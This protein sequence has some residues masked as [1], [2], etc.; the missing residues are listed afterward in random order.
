VRETISANLASAAAHAAASR[1]MDAKR[2]PQRTTTVAASMRPVAA[3][4]TTVR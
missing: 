4:A 2:A 3:G 1:S